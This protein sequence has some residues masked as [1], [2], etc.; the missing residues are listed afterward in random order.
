MSLWEKIKGYNGYSGNLKDK[1][2]GNKF[3]CLSI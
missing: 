2:S 3:F 1:Q